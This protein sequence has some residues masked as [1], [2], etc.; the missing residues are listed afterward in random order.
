MLE[1]GTCLAAGWFVQR[2]CVQ[3]F[4]AAL[5][6]LCGIKERLKFVMVLTPAGT[7]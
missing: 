5:V 2:L 7:E 1:S 3:S 6:F 4:S